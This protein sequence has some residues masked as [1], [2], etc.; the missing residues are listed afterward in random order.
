MTINAECM[1]VVYGKP[2]VISIG[3]QVYTFGA[4][5]PGNRAFKEEYD[6][7]IPDTWNI[8][9][10]AV[11]IPVTIL[12]QEMALALCSSSCQYACYGPR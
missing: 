12:G 1:L 6:Q 11:S 5:R 3:V 9:N 7:L 8:I 2:K 10:D 4:P